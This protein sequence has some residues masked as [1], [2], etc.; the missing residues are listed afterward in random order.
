M[1]YFALKLAK[2][3]RELRDTQRGYT[4]Q[5]ARYTRPERLQRIAAHDPRSTLGGQIIQVAG[6]RLVLR[7]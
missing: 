3:E 4:I 1:G 7:Q 5:L 6:D 2:Q